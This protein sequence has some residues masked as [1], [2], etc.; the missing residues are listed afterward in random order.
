MVQWMF[1]LLQKLKVN[2]TTLVACSIHFP[3]EKTN[4]KKICVLRAKYCIM[5]VIKSVFGQN[6]L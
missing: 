4:K 6:I 5:K 1:D 3:T 2:R